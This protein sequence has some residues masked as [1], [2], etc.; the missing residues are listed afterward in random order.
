M[1][2]LKQPDIPIARKKSKK[3]LW[4]VVSHYQLYLL[5]IPAMVLIFI[6][7]YMPMYGIQIAFRDF[8]TSLGFW[9]SEWVGFY[10]FKRFLSQYNF[11]RL[12]TNT[13]GISLYS[14]AVGFPAPIILAV[15]LNEMRSQKY[16][17][18]IQLVTY[19]PHFI[20]TVVVCGMIHIFLQ[21]ETGII[22]I[23]IEFFG[24]T[25][26]SYLAKPGAFKSIYVFSGVW[27]SVGWGSIIYFA[28]LS[29]IDPQLVEAARIDGANRLQKIW[30]I[31]LPGIRP[32][33]IILLIFNMGGLLSVG[34]EKVLLLQNELNR[35]ASDVI[36]TFVYRTGMIGM[37]YSYTTAIGLFNTIA[38]VIMLVIANFVAKKATETSIW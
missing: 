32:T 24:G 36:S 22:N 13:V 14:L 1:E 11:W 37:Q 29:G 25:G 30:H 5:L 18:T 3:L 19:A 8:K 33:I 21:R 28:A 9:D 15:M 35:S 20:S 2:I 6:F 17:K 4:R 27:Q 26:Q 12:I 34:F 16:K 23:I 10:H 38:N 7:S 31:D